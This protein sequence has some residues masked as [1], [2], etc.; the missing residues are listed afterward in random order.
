[1]SDKEREQ[2]RLELEDFCSKVGHTLA[3][4]IQ[5]SGMS[6]VGF[7]LM[8]FDYGNKGNLAYMS[9]ARRTDML[10]LLDEAKEMLTRDMEAKGD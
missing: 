4:A 2:Q 7:T 1:M 10:K 6:N 9:T 8:M 3:E 5:S